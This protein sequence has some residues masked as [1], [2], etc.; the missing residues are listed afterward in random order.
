MTLHASIHKSCPALLLTLGAALLHLLAACSADAPIDAPEPPALPATYIT[1][2]LQSGA[3]PGSRLSRAENPAGGD[4]GDG[5]D[6]GLPGE[7]RIHSAQLIL[8]TSSLTAPSLSAADRVAAVIPFTFPADAPSGTTFTSEPVPI[9]SAILGASYKAIVVTNLPDAYASEFVGMPLADLR[10]YVYTGTH[11]IQGND[12]MASHH[13]VMTSIAETD[14]TLSIP[15]LRESNGADAD[16]SAER[17][18][19]VTEDPITVERLSARIDISFSD[20]TTGPRDIYDPYAGQRYESAYRLMIPVHNIDADGN[21]V[22]S[23]DYLYPRNILLHKGNTGGT[24]LIKRTSSPADAAVTYFGRETR[25]AAG[26]ATNTVLSALSRATFPSNS[27]RPSYWAGTYSGDSAPN[28]TYTSPQ[29]YTYHLL[30]YVQEHVAA[31]TAAI[32]R[33]LIEAIYYSHGK[34]AAS[35]DAAYSK[36]LYAIPIRHA[37]PEGHGDFTRPV[38]RPMTFG[39]VRNNIYRIRIDKVIKD[40]KYVYIRWYYYDGD[41]EFPVTTATPILANIQEGGTPG[42]PND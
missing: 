13:F 4:D 31:D 14:L 37:D 39:I 21:L 9:S 30:D 19:I 41:T 7:N 2:S 18:Y 1:L 24:Y 28:L 23:G 36:A 27:A 22:E 34:G 10:D 8:Y 6:D 5:R 35:V 25:D 42:Y 29:G 12:L 26:Y 40:T 15:S 17:P 33:L 3:D 38:E 32:T 16:G 11:F 20:Y